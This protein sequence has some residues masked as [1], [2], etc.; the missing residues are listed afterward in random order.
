M[1]TTEARL[2]T[3]PGHCAHQF[4]VLSG[5]RRQWNSLRRRSFREAPV[6]G[7]GRCWQ[8]W[9]TSVSSLCRMHDSAL[10]CIIGH[11]ASMPMCQY[12][13]ARYAVVSLKRVATFKW[14]FKLI[15]QWSH[16]HTDATNEG[17]VCAIN[18]KDGYKQNYANVC[19]LRR[20]ACQ[21]QVELKVLH[22]GHCGKSALTHVPLW[23]LIAATCVLGHCRQQ[24][25]HYATCKPNELTAI[26][27]C[28]CPNVCVRY[29]HW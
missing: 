6:E 11:S 1:R 5:P 28:V 21:R 25:Q 17:P 10:E 19:Q 15:V 22:H 4:G 20:D 2:F 9:F 18:E 12:M 16:K 27:E 23:S 24:C 26:P 13:S 14:Q 8:V 7:S 29:V 3:Q